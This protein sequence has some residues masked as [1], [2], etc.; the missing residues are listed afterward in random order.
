[1]TRAIADRSFSLTPMLLALNEDAVEKQVNRIASAARSQLTTGIIIKHANMP[2]LSDDGKELIER[3]LRSIASR[4]A[5]LKVG[6]FANPQRKDIEE[7]L[8]TYLE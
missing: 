1:M 3:I 7:I 8:V 4:R 6:R 5:E 2:I